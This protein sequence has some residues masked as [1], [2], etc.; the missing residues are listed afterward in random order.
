MRREAHHDERDVVTRLLR[1]VV[2]RG[3]LDAVD[4]LGRGSTGA[5]GQQALDVVGSEGSIRR[6]GVGE[7]VGVEHQGVAGLE[8]ERVV[9]E[10]GVG[11]E[12]E[13]QARPAGRLDRPVGAQEQRQ[14]VAAGGHREPRGGLVELEPRVGGGAELG[15]LFEQRLVELREDLARAVLAD[16]DGAQRVARE[17]GERSRLRSLAADVADDDVPAPSSV[18]NMS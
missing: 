12:A 9:G 13:Q 18:S 6:V 1:V 4:D 10:V 7:A 11:L 16:R 8:L 5:R 17:S 14:R 2:E 3:L 15:S